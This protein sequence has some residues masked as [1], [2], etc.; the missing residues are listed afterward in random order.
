M[1]MLSLFLREEPVLKNLD[2]KGDMLGNGSNALFYFS[3]QKAMLP[4][5]RVPDLHLASSDNKELACSHWL[6]RETGWD[7]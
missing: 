6:G 7:F 4:D 2:R 5:L 3:S 1:V